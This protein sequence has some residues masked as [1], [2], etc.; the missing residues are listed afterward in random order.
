MDTMDNV[1]MWLAGVIFTVLMTIAIHWRWGTGA[2]VLW[3]LFIA[4]LVGIYVPRLL[5][6]KAL[7]DQAK[8][9]REVEWA[10]ER[11]AAG[12]AQRKLVAKERPATREEVREQRQ[13][14][15]F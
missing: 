7:E 1:G 15:A 9:E 10:K 3:V 5:A 13:P 2:A 14:K 6:R 11:E 12:W 8:R 4:V